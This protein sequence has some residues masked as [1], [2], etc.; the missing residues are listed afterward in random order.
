[1]KCS[2]TRWYLEDEDEI[3]DRLVALVQVVL[4]SQAVAVIELHLLVDAGVLEEVQQ[5]LL[6]DP[7]WAEEIHFC[8]GWGGG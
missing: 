4:G 1:M 7:G 6:G 5:D 2:E 3:I 8:G